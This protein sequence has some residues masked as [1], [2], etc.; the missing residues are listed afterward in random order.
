MPDGSATAPQRCGNSREQYWLMKRRDGI[1]AQPHSSGRPAS[2]LGCLLDH[3]VELTKL[4]RE[5]HGL[6]ERVANWRRSVGPPI[7]PLLPTHGKTAWRSQHYGTGTAGMPGAPVVRRRYPPQTRGKRGA[8]DD[9]LTRSLAEVGRHR[10]DRIADQDHRPT[11]PPSAR[12]TIVDVVAYQC[13]HRGGLDDRRDRVVPASKHFEQLLASVLVIVA[14]RFSVAPCV[15][16]HSVTT[17]RLKSE[18]ASTAPGIHPL[19]DERNRSRR[20]DSP[21]VRVAASSGAALRSRAGGVLLTAHRLLQPT[22][23]SRPHLHCRT[24]PAPSRSPVGN[25]Y[26]GHPNGWWWGRAQP[27]VGHGAQPGELK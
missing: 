27:Q 2:S 17:R 25:R 23:R 3:K 16:Q 14:A 6:D 4:Q 26:S 9:C 24:E 18:V 5:R 21:P 10:V 11:I 19:V 20:S 12:P 15:P 13:I 8:V 1:G 22:H 7:D